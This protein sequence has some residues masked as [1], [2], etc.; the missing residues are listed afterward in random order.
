MESYGMLLSHTDTTKEV[1]ASSYSV[2][3]SIRFE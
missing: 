3:I 2:D 1:F